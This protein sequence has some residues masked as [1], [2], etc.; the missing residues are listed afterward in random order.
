MGWVSEKKPTDK[1]VINAMLSITDLIQF[2]NEQISCALV[3]SIRAE[4]KHLIDEPSKEVIPAILI[5]PNEICRSFRI[6]Y[7]ENNGSLRT[8]RP[9][10]PNPE[11]TMKYSLIAQAKQRADERNEELRLAREKKAKMNEHI[12]YILKLHDIRKKA[13]EQYALYVS[14]HKNDEKLLSHAKQSHKR[15]LLM[16]NN[17][18]DEAHRKF[19]NLPPRS[20]YAQKALASTIAIQ[21]RVEENAEQQRQRRNDLIE[22]KRKKSVNKLSQLI[23]IIECPENIQSADPMAGLKSLLS[24]ISLIESN[25]TQ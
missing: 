19:M 1:C 10:P 17:K 21:S 15:R 16:I 8:R 9:F 14:K 11:I 12:K 24:A 13:D 20:E 2:Y 7:V 3:G 25:S 23:E 22:Q 5:H 18:A 6:I 4:I